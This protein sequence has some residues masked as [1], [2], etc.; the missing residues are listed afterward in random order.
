MFPIMIRPQSGV[1]RTGYQQ[2][3]EH[4]GVDT[5]MVWTGNITRQPAFAKVDHR[6]ADGGLPNADRVMETG[7]I[8]PCN[9]SIDDD[10]IA[11]ICEATDEFLTGR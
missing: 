11:Y 4:A 10:G 2:H 8:L 5:R 6:V 1:S 7:L 9:H 3:M